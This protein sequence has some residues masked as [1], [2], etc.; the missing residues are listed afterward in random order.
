MIYH[1]AFLID[2][3]WHSKLITAESSDGL[4]WTD[5]AIVLE[6][7]ADRHSSKRIMGPCSLT[8]RG[9]RRLYF[10][11]E[12][13]SRE[14]RILSAVLSDDLT[15]D[16]EPGA[17]LERGALE[18][19][20]PN[21]DVGGI[22]DPCV[23]EAE[24][25]LLRMYFT[26]LRPD[27]RRS[28]IW[29]ARSTDGLAWEVEGACIR[30][31]QAGMP[32]AVNNPHVIAVAGE[33]RMYLR[34]SKTMPLWSD[35]W[36]ARSTDGQSW[37]NFSCVLRFQRF[38]RLERHGVGFPQVVQIAD[39]RFRMY[40]TGYWGILNDGRVLRYYEEEHRKTFGV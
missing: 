13:D 22:S 8:W 30:S 33:W 29:S 20:F 17:R 18:K 35:I 9:I 26:V 10:V 6:R 40:Y 19:F 3:S 39:G 37:G 32:I 36:M 25:G 21:D 1:G 23:V 27:Q 7:G 15:C 34:T 24:P 38:G 12:D 28:D 31:G 5:K 2:G 4:H 14:A 11:G 16:P